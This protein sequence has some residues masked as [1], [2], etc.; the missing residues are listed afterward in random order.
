MTTENFNVPEVSCG[1]CKSAIETA[2]EPL[3]GVESA[4]VNVE[5]KSVAVVFDDSVIDRAGVVRA[6]ESAGYAVAG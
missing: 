1:H 5:E 4:D 6:I 2:L 3:N